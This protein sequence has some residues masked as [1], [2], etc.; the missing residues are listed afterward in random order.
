MKILL[1][2]T[3]PNNVNKQLL[4][5]T[6]DIVAIDF[7]TL[8]LDKQEFLAQL[9]T[10]VSN[11]HFNLLITYRCPYIIPLATRVLVDKCINIHPVALPEFA[12]ANPWRKLQLSGR[13]TSEVVVHLMADKPDSG[14]IIAKAKYEFSDFSGARNI[15]DET[16][17]NL[18]V[19]QLKQSIYEEH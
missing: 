4:L 9:H 15:A 1:L 7:A 2:T 10:I 18:I 14:T 12:G 11:T 5:I 16:A 3:L 6:S 13:N 17:A 8:C 19:Q